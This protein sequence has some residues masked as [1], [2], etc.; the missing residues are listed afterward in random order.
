MKHSAPKLLRFAYLSIYGLL[1]GWVLF[2][3][4]PAPVGVLAAS[5]VVAG[6]A[7]SAVK[8]SFS[9]TPDGVRV[10]NFWKTYNVRPTDVVEVR[11]NIWSRSVWMLAPNSDCLEIQLRDSTSIVVVAT[12]GGDFRSRGVLETFGVPLQSDHR[13]TVTALMAKVKRW[14]RR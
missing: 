6:A 1:P 9:E 14:V 7:Y 11:W 12:L 3:I 5:A 13:I 8:I 4:L 2:K 10:R